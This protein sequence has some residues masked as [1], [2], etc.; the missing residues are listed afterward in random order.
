MAG[1]EPRMQR[2]I[3]DFC[4]LCGDSYYFCYSVHWTSLRGAIKFYR[5]SPWGPQ[6]SGALKKSPI[7]RRFRLCRA[8]NWPAIRPPP[9]KERI[10]C[11]ILNKSRV[12]PPSL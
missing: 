11:A 10:K 7:L 2:Y 6:M 4:V 1:P 9:K 5:F 3:S 8:K 12:T